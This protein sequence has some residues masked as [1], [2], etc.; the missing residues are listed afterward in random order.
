MRKFLILIVCIAGTFFQVRVFGQNKNR[1][2]NRDF[3]RIKAPAFHYSKPDMEDVIFEDKLEG[4]KEPIYFNPENELSLV[5]EGTSETEDED[6]LSAG[7]IVEEIKMDCVW[8]TIAEYFAIWDSKTVNPYKVD[9]TTYSDTITLKLYDSTSNFFY[10]MPVDPCVIN[11][12]FGMRH[13]RW[14]YGTDLD[15]NRGD[16]VKAAFDGI[17]RIKKY[18]RSGYGN[19]VLLRHYNGLETIYGHLTESYVKVG[20]LV[21]AGEVIGA[22]GSTGR[23]T[24]PHLHFEVRYEGNPINPEDMY[25]FENK[26]LR[27][28]IF[29]LTP[30]H[31]EYIKTVRQVVYHRI[32]SG[33]TL[34]ALSRRYRVSVNTICRLNGM[35]SRSILRVGQ[36]I[37]IR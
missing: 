24:G 8:V 16:P 13:W 7:G 35:S 29:E 17:V 31:F 18:D 26:V 6:E 20:Q 37:R 3:F 5:R 21:K 10:S 36:R 14:H 25:D 19:Y 28:N 12:D 2:K 9:P 22:G 15:L 30:K 33:D 34:S 1:I 4:D 27:E 32:R 11:S 23:S